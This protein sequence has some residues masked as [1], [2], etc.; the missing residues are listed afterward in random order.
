MRRAGLVGDADDGIV[1]MCVWSMVTVA[2]IEPSSVPG[3][4]R[5]DLA[6]RR[7][8]VALAGQHDGLALEQPGAVSTLAAVHEERPLHGVQLRQLL[9]EDLRVAAVDAVVLVRADVDRDCGVPLAESVLAC[10]SMPVRCA[11]LEGDLDVVVPVDAVE[12][13]LELLRERADAAGLGGARRLRLGEDAYDLGRAGAIV[14]FS[15]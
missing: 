9:R 4:D 7:R 10:R 3:V 2:A 15:V 11:E 14:S 12:R 5:D 1:G 13:D 6:H 8:H